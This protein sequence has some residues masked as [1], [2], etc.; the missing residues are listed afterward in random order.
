MSAAKIKT[1]VVT[2][3]DDGVF[4]FAA[5]SSET[6]NAQLDITMKTDWT[7]RFDMSQSTAL[8][9]ISTT[10]DGV[11]GEGGEMSSDGI[12]FYVDGTE[13]EDIEEGLSAAAQFLAAHTAGEGEEG[14][15][16]DSIYVDIDAASF[17]QTAMYYYNA[18]SEAMGGMFKRMIASMGSVSTPA[19]YRTSGGEHHKASPAMRLG[20]KGAVRSAALQ[21]GAALSALSESTSKGTKR[22]SNNSGHP[23][24]AGGETVGGGSKGHS[25]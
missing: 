20:K 8:F 1:Y 5:G 11:H 18:D 25:N 15:W 13:L 21:K 23:P 22:G 4:S 17:T 16:A 10:E 2:V 6:S 19:S 12:K 24:L 14:G 3:D 7:Y 9:A